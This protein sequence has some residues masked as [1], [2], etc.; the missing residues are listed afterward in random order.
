MV[1]HETARPR[2]DMSGKHRLPAC[3]FGQL[4]KSWDNEITRRPNDGTGEGCRS[5]TQHRHAAFTLAELLVTVGILVMLVLLFTQLLNSAATI[6]TLGHKQMDADS[7]GRQLLDQMAIDLA[8]MIKRSDVDYY[9]KSPANPQTGG[10]DQMAFYTAVPGYY[11]TSPSP[12]PTYTTKSPLSLVSYR[13]NSDTT[14][15]SY[16]RTERLGK[17]LA[18]NGF[19]S[20]WVPVVFLPQ[21]ISGTWASAVSTSVADSDYEVVGSEVFRLEYY[22][23]LKNGSLSITPWDTGAGHTSIS[24]MQDI[25]AIVADFAVIDP[26]SKV[27]LTNAQVA[28]LNTSGAANFLSNYASGMAPGQLRAQWQNTLDGITTL[29]R[30][31]ISGIRLYERY[32]YLSPPTLLTP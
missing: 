19:S 7:R 31:A 17:G 25:A 10:N 9:L 1:D 27:L 30:P 13:V 15:P 16:N 12:A 8:Q 21:T 20:G 22:Y 5:T 3:R 28:T 14:S 4:A 26:K 32:F 18:W 2:D 11:P 24:G 29:P 6:T 23:L